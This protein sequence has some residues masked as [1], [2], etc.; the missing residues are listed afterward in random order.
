M[1]SS[2]SM[3]RAALSARWFAFYVVSVGAALLLVP[4]LLLALF[5]MA[6]TSEIW[7]RVVGLVAF[8]L[9]VYAWISAHHRRFLQASVYTRALVFI[10]LAGFV[11]A[12]MAE[13]MLALFGVVDLCGAI[14]TWLALRVDDQARGALA[15][16]VAAAARP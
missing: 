14:W 3:P 8:N 13:P 2:Q 15:V 10:V 4:N 11:L 5:G 7:I 12:G 16:G 9:G 1:S 6:P